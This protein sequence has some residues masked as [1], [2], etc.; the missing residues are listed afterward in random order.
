LFGVVEQC[1]CHNEQASDF[2]YLLNYRPEKQSTAMSQDGA[3]KQVTL[4]ISATTITFSL[5]QA[6][7]LSTRHASALFGTT[8]EINGTLFIGLAT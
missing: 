2:N 6:R 4:I 1:L 3:C 5:P 8:I 7:L